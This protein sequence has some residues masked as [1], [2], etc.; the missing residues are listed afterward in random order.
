MGA[1]NE[2]YLPHHLRGRKKERER[3]NYTGEVSHP[4]EQIRDFNV[5]VDRS[6]SVSAPNGR[7]IEVDTA[8]TFVTFALAWHVATLSQ[9]GYVATEV[10][11]DPNIIVDTIVFN[12]PMIGNF[13]YVA[14]ING[15]PKWIQQIIGI[16]G[17]TYPTALA[18]AQPYGDVMMPLGALQPQ[19]LNVPRK[20]YIVHAIAFRGSGGAAAD[21]IASVTFYNSGELP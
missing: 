21:E 8:K 19:T 11:I 16:S 3:S 5:R 18:V 13:G 4:Q 2:I 9:A 10:V 12:P 20:R 14:S 7:V 1:W 17:L 6:R 15:S